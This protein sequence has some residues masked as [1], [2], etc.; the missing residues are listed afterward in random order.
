M[1]EAAELFVRPWT[2]LSC[3]A[4][5]RM[6]LVGT[7]STIRRSAGGRRAAIKLASSGELIEVEIPSEF[8]IA[9]DDTVFLRVLRG[10]AFAAP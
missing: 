7:V 3:P 6:P 10:K 1:T 5:H 8:G 4:P 9:A 2:L